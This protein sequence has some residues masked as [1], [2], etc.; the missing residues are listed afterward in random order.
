MGAVKK[1]SVA[2]TEELAADVE[3]AVASG[4]YVSASEVIREALRGWKGRRAGREG[5]IARLRALW[6][7][8]LASGEPKAVTEE[9]FESIRE[10]G[11]ERL[12]RLRE[13]D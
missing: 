4:D 10:R 5:E 8:G 11:L 2:L 13:Q 1:I 6:D 7:E 3:Q 12:A 9:W